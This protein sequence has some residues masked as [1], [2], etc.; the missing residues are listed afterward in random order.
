MAHKSGDRTYGWLIKYTF[1][2]DGDAT[3]SR[4]FD[5]VLTTSSGEKRIQV[6][7]EYEKEKSEVVWS[8]TKPVINK[9][10]RRADDTFTGTKHEFRDYEEY[11]GLDTGTTIYT[12]IKITIEQKENIWDGE[13]GTYILNDGTLITNKAKIG[14]MWIGDIASKT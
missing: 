9:V 14:P 10:I 4:P 11:W 13:E 3:D 7:A 8:K 5:I 6:I 2:D 1:L 12:D